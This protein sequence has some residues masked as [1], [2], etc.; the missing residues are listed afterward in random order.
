MVEVP[1]GRAEPFTK[2]A[3][4][5]EHCARVTTARCRCAERSSSRSQRR[6]G[7]KQYALLC[8]ALADT[9]SNG[10]TSPLS[11][12]RVHSPRPAARINGW[13][14]RLAS[15]P[16]PIPRLGSGSPASPRPRSGSASRMNGQYP[17][18]TTAVCLPSTP[19]CA[20]GRIRSSPGSW[21][22]ASQLAPPQARPV[23]P[24]SAPLT[25]RL[26]S[27]PV[28]AGQALHVEQVGPAQRSFR[29]EHPCRGL[30]PRTPSERRP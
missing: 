18:K 14:T 25:L 16:G 2:S 1:E 4:R 29:V 12:K 13:A 17:G 30:G 9:S 22:S 3:Q 28:A 8:E 21:S 23:W 19:T 7:N 20:P 24:G 5:R 26:P 6:C 10:G 11:T 15:G 27:V